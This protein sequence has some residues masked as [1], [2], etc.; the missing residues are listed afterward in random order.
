MSGEIGKSACETRR[1]IIK[2][3]KD[4]LDYRF[5]GD[6]S[7]REHNSNVDEQLIKI[8]LTQA[9]YS[10]AQISSAVYKL[11]LRAHDTGKDL[12]E[13]NQ[14]VYSYLRYGIEADTEFGKPKDQVWLIDWAASEKNQFAIA[15]NVA[16]GGVPQSRLDLVLFVNGIAIGTIELGSSYISVGDGIRQSLA[17]QQ[18]ELCGWFYST[19]QFV[20][21]GSDSEG[22]RYGTIG[23]GERSF[24]KWKE[25]SPHSPRPMLAQALLHMCSKSRLL[26]LT[27]DFVLFDGGIK[28]LPRAHQYFGVKKAQEHVMARQSGI[29]WHTQGSGKSIV[30][31]ILARWIL[32]NY[33]AAR[34]LSET[35]ETISSGSSSGEISRQLSQGKPGLLRSLTHR[36][37]LKDSQKMSDRAFGEYVRELASQPGPN[38]GEVFVFVDDCHR[39]HSDRL[40]RLIK[41]I[42][43]NAVFIGFTG[44]PL[45]KRDKTHC[46]E[47]FGSY[48]HT[49]TFSEA[50]EDGVVLDLVYEA[51]DIDRLGGG[52][53]DQVDQ[54]FEAKTKGLSAWQKSKLKGRW[55]TNQSALG[56]CSRTDRVVCDILLDFSSKPRLSSQRGSA[57]LI[58]QSVH[59]A[60]K[61][62]LAFNKTDFKG[63]CALITSYDPY[64]KSVSQE[65]VGADSETDRRFIYNTYRDL[66]ADVSA[67]SGRTQAETYEDRAKNR[68]IQEPENMRLLIV[69]DKLLT[70]F[71]A[72]ACTYLYIDKSMQDH[73]LFQAICRTNRL[74]G[75]DK[76]LGHIVDYKRQL[77]TAPKAVPVYSSEL[78]PPAD[79]NSS[80]KILIWQ[81]LM[82]GKERLEGASRTFRLVCEPVAPPRDALQYIRYFCGNA[83][84]PTDLQARAPL[85]R[86]L[87]KASVVFIRAYADIADG[88]VEAGYSRN[89][90]VSIQRQ[91]T[92][93]L[94]VRET[95][96]NAADEICDLKPFEADMPHLLE[97][98][99]DWGEP[100]QK[101]SFTS[102]GLLD[103]I[104]RIGINAAITERLGGLRGQ[105]DAIAETIENNIRKKIVLEKPA[106]TAFYQRMSEQ[107]DKSISDRRAQA[108][109]FETYLERIAE[110]AKKVSAGMAED[111]PATLDTPGK[112]AIYN[113]LRGLL[114]RPA[115][116]GQVAEVSTRYRSC[117]GVV[118]ELTHRIDQTVKDVRPDG[119][120][121]IQTREEVIKGALFGVLHDIDQVEAVFAIVF[122][123]PEY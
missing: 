41:A 29:I 47:L 74:D 86:A 82:K 32:E 9:G 36:F 4:E 103:L 28:R 80:S 109:T 31:A 24:M 50:V 72:P 40:H 39:T 48:I 59:Q 118:L 2:L 90:M 13:R 14:G 71:D 96:R 64:F 69:V 98:Y 83:E 75:E 61:Y 78:E 89:E 102:I 95:V 30:M 27:H 35:G 112:R 38:L 11:T 106:D 105:Q 34:V 43:P 25:D 23:M 85:R 87:Y 42:M 8:Y 119:W 18:D 16:L 5:L 66:L 22:L 37:G 77:K 92:H 15:E 12:Y 114:V 100:G 73:G 51:R 81:R 93:L 6:W 1:R 68:F 79:P 46:L 49:Y 101:S 120:R 52:S 104:V 88:L 65:E 10:P 33:P 94:G 58:A 111:T 55:E 63:K 3:F 107:L 121:G 7:I 45:M 99:V 84:I 110:L 91:L 44:T 60:C 97:N 54:W 123:Q 115:G 117:E 19:V 67:D 17:N 53:R 21:A 70:G 113:K 56:A 122:A 26:E 62:F 20:F 76:D 116:A 108:I 57:M